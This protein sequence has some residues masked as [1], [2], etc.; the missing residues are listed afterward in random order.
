M[1]K[2]TNISKTYKVYG[3]KAGLIEAFKSLFKRKYK[4]I[5]ALK[6]VSFEIN[7]GELKGFYY[8]VS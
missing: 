7:E 6:D 8:E 5:E 1:I 2:L 3:R 4:I